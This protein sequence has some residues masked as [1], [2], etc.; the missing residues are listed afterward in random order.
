MHL[1]L[2]YWYIYYQPLQ[3]SIQLGYCFPSQDWH[4]SSDEYMRLKLYLIYTYLHKVF[5][6]SIYIFCTCT[7]SDWQCNRLWVQWFLRTT[8][9][10]I[11]PWRWASNLNVPAC[12]KT[13]IVTQARSKDVNTWTVNHFHTHWRW[14]RYI[15]HTILSVTITELSATAKRY[16]LVIPPLYWFT[17][18]C[19]TVADN[20]FSITDRSLWCTVQVYCTCNC[21][22]W[23]FDII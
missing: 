10:T 23:E 13:C 3:M 6:E 5:Y 17:T 14:T 9:S 1:L 21:I 2:G 7:V 12:A 19:C 20:F 4:C 15:R 18:G 16:S 11:D 22:K 8:S